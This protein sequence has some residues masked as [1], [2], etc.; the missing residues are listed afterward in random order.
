LGLLSLARLELE[1][2][3]QSGHLLS[4]HCLPRNEPRG[5]SG[6]DP[7]RRRQGDGSIGIEPSYRHTSKWVLASKPPAQLDM[8][9]PNL[10]RGR[11]GAGSPS[12]RLLRFV[13]CQP[14]VDFGR[15]ARDETFLSVS[16]R[17]TPIGVDKNVGS[18]KRNSKNLNFTAL[19]PPPIF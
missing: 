5:R 12:V 15:L 6:Q 2:A 18:I 19:Y 9:R 16:C 3:A 1:T 10:R 11:T 7:W 8:L 13:I 14:H 17:W 4:G